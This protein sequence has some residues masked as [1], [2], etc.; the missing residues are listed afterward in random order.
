[1]RK[2]AQISQVFTYLVIILV[3]GVIIIFGYKGISWIINTNCEHQRIV[4]E[5]SILGFIDEYSNKGSVHEEVLNAPCGVTQVCFVDA[6]YYSGAVTK[7][8]IQDNVMASSLE[9][10]P[11]N[12]IFIKTKFTEPVG[13]SNKVTLRPEDRPYKCFNTTSSGKFRFLFRGLG[14]KTQIESSDGG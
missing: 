9:T 8:E 3:V 11:Y 6:V 1:M 14:R 12:N 4:F 10:Q 5:K 7:P 2:K 13:F